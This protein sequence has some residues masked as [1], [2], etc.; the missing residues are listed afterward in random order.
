MIARPS[1]AAFLLAPALFASSGCLVGE[2]SGIPCGDDDNCPTNH[3]CDLEADVCVA[4][5]DGDTPPALA[6][7]GVIDGNG[8][9]TVGPF[10][11]PKERTELKLVIE[12]SGTRV[13]NALNVELTRLVCMNLEFDTT[14]V[15]DHIDGGDSIEVAFAVTPDG[16]STPTIQDWFVRYSGRATRGT[17]NINIERQAPGE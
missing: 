13:A 8:D 15:P 11:P 6:V 12:N 2:L 9:V 7:T 4:L 10:V 1:F 3:F 16:C 17:F 5:T 14:R